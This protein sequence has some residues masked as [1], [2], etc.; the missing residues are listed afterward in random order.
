[1]A[2]ASA[3][4]EEDGAQEDDVIWDEEVAEEVVAPRSYYVVTAFWMSN[5]GKRAIFFKFFRYVGKSAAQDKAY[6]LALNHLLSSL[7]EGEKQEFVRNSSGSYQV[8]S[9]DGEV[10]SVSVQEKREG[11]PLVAEG[12]FGW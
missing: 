9:D 2:D 5:V 4:K 3:Q 7:K 12:S 11:D 1:M 10:L 8:M 6:N